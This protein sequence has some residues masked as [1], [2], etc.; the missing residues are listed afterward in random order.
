MV[1]GI[2]GACPQGAGQDPAEIASEF[3]IHERMDDLLTFHA[4]GSMTK[5][6]DNPNS[7]NKG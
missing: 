4:E 7:P 2:G 6:D 5:A 1:P 3:L